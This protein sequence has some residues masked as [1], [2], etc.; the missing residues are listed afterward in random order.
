MNGK[1][2]NEQFPSEIWGKFRTF[3]IVYA[4]ASR[5]IT[6]YATVPAPDSVRTIPLINTLRPRQN[7]RQFADDLFKRIFLNEN[8]CIL[9]KISLKLVP[10]DPIYNISALVQIM[11]W[12]R[13]AIIW[14]NDG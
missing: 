8:V 3:Y 2:T 9:T 10:R 14:T 7:G 1:N 13:Q 6:S 11:A 5:S 4:T 12:R